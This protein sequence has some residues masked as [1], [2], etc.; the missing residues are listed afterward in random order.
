MA[1]ET[2][3][4]RIIVTHKQTYMVK[5]PDSLTPL[6]YWI[7]GMLF[8]MNG[9]LGFATSLRQGIMWCLVGLMFAVIGFHEYQKG[10]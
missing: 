10:E 4:I 2:G 3:S 5:I 6:W 1:Q 7:I 8:L 9:F